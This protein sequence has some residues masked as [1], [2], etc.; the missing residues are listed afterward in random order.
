L[1]TALRGRHRA[2]ADS[3]AAARSGDSDYRIRYATYR[4]DPDLQEAHRR[5]PFIVVWD[6]H[7]ITNVRGPVE[8]S[9][10]NPEQGEGDWPTRQAAAYR[11]YLEWMPVREAPGTGIHLYR[12]FRFGSLLDVIMLDTRGLR[13][14]QAA[15]AVWRIAA[16]IRLPRRAWMFDQLRASQQAERDGGCWASRSCS[17]ASFNPAGP[18]CCRTWEGYQAS[19]DGF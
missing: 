10:H 2:A 3:G 13:D 6:D 15:N 16:A 14:R 17:P 12:S 9:N 7:E 19:R 18:C 11:A 1:R 8:P 4:T 5:H